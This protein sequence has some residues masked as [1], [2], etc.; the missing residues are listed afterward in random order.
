MIRNT[1]GEVSPLS[2]FRYD[3]FFQFGLH[4]CNT[5]QPL[6]ALF[7]YD[8]FSN[9]VAQVYYCPATT[10]LRLFRYVRFQ[11]CTSVIPV[12]FKSGLTTNSSVD[13]GSVTCIDEC[14]RRKPL[15]RTYRIA[16][17]KSE[18]TLYIS[19]ALLSVVWWWP[20]L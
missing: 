15:P 2:I 7:R 17:V 6:R 16:K 20:L 11:F 1:T 5:Q 8:S 4:K 12:V 10:S 14:H 19:A 9:L 3:S 13:G 18:H